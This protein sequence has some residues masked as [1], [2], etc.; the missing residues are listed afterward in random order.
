MTQ[1]I[2]LQRRAALVVAGDTGPLHLAAAL[3]RPVVGLYG[4]TDPQRTGPYGCLCRVLRHA[5]SV[6]D[7]SRHDGTE[8]GLQKITAA[9]VIRAAMDVL[10]ESSLGREVEGAS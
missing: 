8:V 1:M 5:D 2:A 9:E 7:H 6:V 4:P 10:K 3:K